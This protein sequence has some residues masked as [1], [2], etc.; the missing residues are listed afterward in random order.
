[1]KQPK[2]F[3]SQKFDSETLQSVLWETLLNVRGNKLEV[4]KANSIIG[5]AKEI[6][7]IARLDIQRELL[8]TQLDNIERNAI[9]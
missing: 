9:E 1:M 6:C 4:S 5:A 8:N 7:N 2:T 3:S